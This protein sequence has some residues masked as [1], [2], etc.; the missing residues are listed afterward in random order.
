LEDIGIQKG[1]QKDVY[2]GDLIVVV[3]AIRNE[4]QLKEIQG[5]CWLKYDYDVRKKMTSPLEGSGHYLK[6]HL[7]ICSTIM[8]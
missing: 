8:L 4:A 6:G 5:A 2:T 7:G 3:T 1:I